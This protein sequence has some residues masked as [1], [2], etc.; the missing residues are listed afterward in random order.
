MRKSIVITWLQARCSQGEN[1][2]AMLLWATPE[3]TYAQVHETLCVCAGCGVFGG[4]VSFWCAGVC[5]RQEYQ[6]CYACT[7]F[8]LS[9]V[10]TFR[11]Y[12]RAFSTPQQCFTLWLWKLLRLKCTSWI[13]ACLSL[14]CQSLPQ[15]D[16]TKQP[17]VSPCFLKIAVWWEPWTSRSLPGLLALPVFNRWG[18]T[19]CPLYP[20]L[21]LASRSW[22]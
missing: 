7:I 17:V 8:S 4:S 16:S 2:R 21:P 10:K 12:L 6:E 13:F 1:R 3:D 5:V 11:K 15:M 14:L 9:A 20:T 19:S 18:L 22:W